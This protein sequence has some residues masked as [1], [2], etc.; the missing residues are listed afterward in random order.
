M[1]NQTI[2]VWWN[3]YCHHWCYHGHQVCSSLTQ[4]LFL[5]A[6]HHMIRTYILPKSHITLMQSLKSI[7]SG[8]QEKKCTKW[9]MWSPVCLEYNVALQEFNHLIIMH[10][11]KGLRHELKGA[12]QTCQRWEQNLSHPT[13][14]QMMLLCVTYS[15]RNSSQWQ[16][17]CWWISHYRTKNR[18]KTWEK[19]SFQ[20]LIQ[21]KG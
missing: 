8:R 6:H 15:H 18:W 5:L 10:K 21:E 2:S 12:S 19:S 3:I 16:W 14:F 1:D 13:H 20:L 17:W 11:A 7:G 9:T 4:N